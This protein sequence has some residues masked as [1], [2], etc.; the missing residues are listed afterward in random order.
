MLDEFDVGGADVD[1]PLLVAGLPLV[2]L[3]L[4]DSLE[5]ALLPPELVGVP[6]L[7]LL[8]PQADSAVAI[9]A[10]AATPTSSR[11]FFIGCYPYLF[12]WAS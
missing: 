11:V 12:D 1:P 3:L 2:E 10:V 6:L 5:V 8:P 4:A 9:A 7:P